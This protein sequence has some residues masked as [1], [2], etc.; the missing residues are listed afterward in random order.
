[1]GGLLAA[2]LTLG[3]VAGGVAASAAGGPLYGPRLWLE[4]ATLPS[5]ATERADAQVVRLDDRLAEVRSALAGHDPGATSAALDA[6]TAILA[7][8]ESQAAADPV[9]ADRVRDDVS[10][11]LAV[12][13]A[14]IGRVPEQAKGALQHALDRSDAAVDHLG[15]VGTGRPANP[16]SNG[17]GGSGGSGQGG[18][19]DRTPQGVPPTKK[20][21]KTDAPPKATQKPARTPSAPG[22]TPKPAKTAAP[23]TEPTENPGQGPSS[24]QTHAQGRP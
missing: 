24:G 1:M 14:L 15:V 22:Q 3:L 7:E 23:E 2:A 9:L 17:V 21:A 8:L 20:P 10:R 16:G 18:G 6:Y 4:S 12:L 5:G 11:H 13:E 19:P